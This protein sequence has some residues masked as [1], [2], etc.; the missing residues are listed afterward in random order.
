MVVEVVHWQLDNRIHRLLGVPTDEGGMNVQIDVDGVLADFVKGFYDAARYYDPKTPFITTHEQETWHDWIGIP[1]E[2]QSKIWKEIKESKVW[3]YELDPL[4]TPAERHALSQ[5][6]YIDGLNLYFVT[7]RP[8]VYS[9]FLTERWIRTYCG[10]EHPTVIIAS[11]KGLMSKMLN[12]DIS[13]EDNGPNAEAI[14]K[15]LWDSRNS[16]LINRRYNNKQPYTASRI[17]TLGAFVEVVRGRI[18]KA[19]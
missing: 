4:P 10:M 14:G 19:S 9:K 3:W 18:H 12:I 5:L 7:S 8:G 6:D 11:N 1:E 17:D 2:T 13:I 16:Y 15:N